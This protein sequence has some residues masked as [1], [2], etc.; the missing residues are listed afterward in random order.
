MKYAATDLINGVKTVVMAI[1]LGAVPGFDPTNPPQE[2][3]YGVADAVQVGWIK[4]GDDF[5]PP[6]VVDPVIP[7]PIVPRVSALQGLL[8]ID[9]AGLAAQYEAWAS[10]PARTFAERA[11]IN[12]A[13]TWR[14][15][16]P[17]IQAAAVALG[18]TS[19]QV[20]A[21]FDAAALI[22]V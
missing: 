1:P 14:R 12:K 22:V 19:Q 5:V 10:A 9:Q 11:F 20:D 17:T 16:D 6:P 13:M 18:L 21:L 2:N 8:A 4:Q 7:P 3:T 15:D